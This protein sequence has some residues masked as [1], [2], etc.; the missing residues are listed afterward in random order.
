MELRFKSM[1]L[2]LTAAGLMVTANRTK[3]IPAFARKY[4]ISCTTCHVAIPKLNA[5]GKAFRMNGYRFPRETQEQVEEKP[6]PLGGEPQ[7]KL[8]PKKAV[9]PGA[10]P[11]TVPLAIR[12]ESDVRITPQSD[13]KS[14]FRLPH[15]LYILS[16]GNLGE[17]ISFFVQFVAYEDGEFGELE[18]AFIQFDSPFWGNPLLNIKIGQIEPAAVPFTGI[19]RITMEHYPT[20]RFQNGSNPFRFKEPQRG[21]EIWGIR[22]GSRGGG[23]FYGLGLVNGNGGDGKGSAGT[24]DDN[25]AKDFY[26]RL[27]YKFGGLSL[28]GEKG[29]P[30][31]G[32][33]WVD[34]SLSLGGYGY[35]GWASASRFH[36][37]GVDFQWQFKNLDLFGTWMWGEDSFSS[38]MNTTETHL[39][40]TAYFVEADYV[41]LPWIIGALR[42]GATRTPDDPGAPNL[43]E[44]MAHLTFSIRPNV[45]LRMEGVGTLNGAEET[46]GRLRLDFAF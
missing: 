28:T 1:I 13:V 36:R 16:G 7:K 30:P 37:W 3:A 40:F 21:I 8:F 33:S 17:S 39:A 2:L 41:I 15:E 19:R 10:I 26:G 18:R 23:L 46:R 45:M 29:P 25:S 22:D 20:S 5:F 24:L 34:N 42:Y 35:T 11:G 31:Q 6:V 12:L 38:A 14:D 27:R 44:I 4:K 43:K 32:G 9:Y